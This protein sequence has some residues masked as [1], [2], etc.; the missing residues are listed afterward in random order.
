MTKCIL[1]QN[2]ARAGKILTIRGKSADGKKTKEARRLLPAV[3]IPRKVKY[4][5]G[6]P[7]LYRKINKKQ[8][9]NQ[10]HPKEKE[11]SGQRTA[12]TPRNSSSMAFLKVQ[13]NVAS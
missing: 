13:E 1:V 8:N 9:C 7:C 12:G 3:I 6:T 11:A 10:Y 2:K 4:I 5:R